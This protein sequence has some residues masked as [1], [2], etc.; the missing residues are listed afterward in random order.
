VLVF[1]KQSKFVGTLL[2]RLRNVAGYR[3]V[4]W[5]SAIS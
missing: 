4:H 2:H 5:P 3:S 1:V